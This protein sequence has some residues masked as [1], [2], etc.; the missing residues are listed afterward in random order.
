MKI[1]VVCQYYYPEPF[2]HPEICEEFVRRGHEVTVV[3][4]VPNYPMGEIYEGYRNGEKR[5]EIINGVKVHRCFTFGRKHGVIH[6]F[7]NYYS[8]V[9]SSTRYVTSIRDKYD[10]VF[11]NQ[12]SPV[13]MAQAAIRY[14]NKHHVPMVMYCLDLW[15]ESLVAGGIRRGSGIYKAFE[16]VSKRIYKEADRIFVTSHSFKDYFK[17]EFGIDDT[18]YL[19]Q[20]AEAIFTP[21]QCK[22]KA[23]EYIDLMFAGNVGLAQ[24]VD[25]IIKA[26]KLTADIKNLRWHI[27]GDGSEI[28]KLKKMSRGL[29]SVIFHGRKPLEEM[30]KYYAMADAM[31]VTM[32][33]DP[34]LNKT[35]PGKVQTYMAAGK[36]IIGAIDGETQLVIYDAGCGL[37]GEAGNAEQLAENVRTF[38]TYD[39]SQ[40]GKKAYRYYTEHF[41]K[42]RFMDKFEQALERKNTVEI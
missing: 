21:E 30:P 38:I 27:V 4:G 5:E 14:K 22:K 29:N 6:R 10:V 40:F 24:S 11:V 16:R 20:F 18:I 41:E 28:S 31:L 39:R 2:R 26:A 23:D 17:N 32:Q 3:T 34:M 25:T 36:P 13:M 35:L 37:C 9:F 1:L 33:K 8:F 12:L 19:P 7:L 42:Q 15:P